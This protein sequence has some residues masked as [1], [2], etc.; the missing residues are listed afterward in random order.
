MSIEFPKE[1]IVIDEHSQLYL[2]QKPEDD[3]NKIFTRM[4]EILKSVWQITSN[5]KHN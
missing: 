5:K 2:D 3:E 4:R 1:Q